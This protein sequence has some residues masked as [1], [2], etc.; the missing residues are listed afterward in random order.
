MSESLFFTSRDHGR[1]YDQQAQ[2]YSQFKDSSFSWRFLEQPAFD[3]HLSDL[4]KPETNVLDL[5]CGPGQ[6]IKHLTSRGIKPEHIT[7]LDISLKLL[8]IAK[9]ENPGVNFILSPIEQ[10]HLTPGSFDLVTTNT[11]FHHL[12]NQ[13]LAE[14]LERIYQVLKPKGVLFFVD[15]DPDHSQE[16]R[17]PNNVNKWTMVNTPWGTHVPFFNRD[18]REFL[19]L[20]DLYGFDL[21]SGGVLKVSDEGMSDWRQYI[22]YSSRPSRMAGRF[23]KVSPELKEKRTR[24]APSIVEL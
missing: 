9:K 2:A 5:G 11:V 7:G 8:K 15:T 14:S 17:D 12:N 3:K 20:I 1:I 19:N 22:N 6:V 18:P 23:Y 10:F 13:Q 4:Y 24:K 21:K 16:G